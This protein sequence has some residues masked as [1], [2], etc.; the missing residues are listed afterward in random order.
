MSMHK[1][2]SSVDLEEKS[3]LKTFLQTELNEY[4]QEQMES[5]LFEGVSEFEKS[6]FIGDLFKW[7]RNA[8]AQKPKDTAF[9]QSQLKEYQ[10]VHNATLHEQLAQIGSGSGADF[11][12]NNKVR[13]YRWKEIFKES[14][15]NVELPKKW[16]GKSLNSSVFNTPEIIKKMNEKNQTAIPRSSGS[17]SKSKAKMV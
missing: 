7:I 1:T 14:P 6:E 8:F 9:A 3:L 11:P 17:D 12:M 15:E 16:V 4:L 13:I 2:L 5:E 10:Q